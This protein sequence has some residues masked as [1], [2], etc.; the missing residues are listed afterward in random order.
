MLCIFA[1]QPPSDDEAE[2]ASVHSL[3]VPTKELIFS[4]TMEKLTTLKTMQQGDY[5]SYY[6]TWP[7][8][9]IKF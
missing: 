3:P 9:S 2:V 8:T 4:P 7:P 1:G 5:P 6:A